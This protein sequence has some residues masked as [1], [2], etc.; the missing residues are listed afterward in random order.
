MTATAAR[1]A[2]RKPLSAAQAAVRAVEARAT[3]ENVAALYEALGE[4]H[5]M[6]LDNQAFDII[7]AARDQVTRAEYSDAWE[8]LWN[9]EHEVST[10]LVE[11]DG[12]NAGDDA[13]MAVAALAVHCARAFAGGAGTE[14]SAWYRA[15]TAGVDALRAVVSAVN[16][17]TD[18]RTLNRAVVTFL[19]AV[20][21]AIPYAALYEARR[22]LVEFARVR[23]LFIVGMRQ[24]RADDF[25]W[26]RRIGAA[27]Y[28]FRSGP[29]FGSVSVR[30][31]ADDGTVG[32]ERHF[33]LSGRGQ[34]AIAQ[35]LTRL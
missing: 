26:A 27:V 18:G 4:F 1:A 29:P 23:G 3:R 13:I 24:P 9:A 15:D 31:I 25:E 32:P 19:D 22:A 11:P 6:G 12:P 17:H 2:M 16:G 30:R 7:R 8:L 14:R 34:D 5:P 10:W 28:L 35:A 20:R 33:S 21:R